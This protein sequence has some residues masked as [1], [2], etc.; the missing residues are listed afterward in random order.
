MTGNAPGK[1]RNGTGMMQQT[2]VVL[3]GDIGGTKT[4]L[5]VFEV[6]GTALKTLAEAVYPS[7]DY[8]AFTEIVQEFLNGHACGC[9]GACFGVAGPVRQGICETTNLPWRLVAADLGR[10]LGI[11]RV[12]LLNDLEAN[13]WGLRAWPASR[14]YPSPANP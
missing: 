6:A 5:A 9:D 8:P 2:R 4:R 13:A 10:S 11:A 7:R 14:W 3:A 1:R 12:A